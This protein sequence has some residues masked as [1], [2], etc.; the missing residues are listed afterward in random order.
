MSCK[1]TSKT[2]CGARSCEICYIRSFATH[3]RAECWSDR[4]EL[5][6]IQVCKSSNKKFWFDCKECGH[7]LELTANRV[8]SGGWCKYCNKG[9]LCDKEDC[10]PCF[11]SSF[12]SHPMAPLWS[13]NNACTPRM[14]SKGSEKRCWFVCNVCQHIY[15]SVLY[16]LKNENHCPYCANQKLCECDDCMICYTKSCASH[17]MKNAW[18]IKNKMT[19]RQTHLQSNKSVIFNCLTCYHEYETKVG[20]YYHREGSCPYCTNK[21]LCDNNTCTMCF[22]KSFAS[23][24]R[25]ACW[26]PKNKIKP[27]DIFKGSETKCIFNCDI[28]HSEF[29]SRLY[30]V[31][32]GYWCPFCKNKSEAKMLQ[33]LRELYPN[34]KSQ[35]RFDWCRFSKTNNVMPVDFGLLDKKILIELDGEQHF[36]QISNWD[37]PENVQAKDVEKIEHCIKNGYS[38]IHIYQVDV[39]KDSYDWKVVLQQ[40]IEQVVESDPT[41]VFISSNKECY[42]SHIQLLHNSIP[43]KQITSLQ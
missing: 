34:C 32:T 35:L 9:G 14:I 19:A 15:D 16:I 38:I 37:A 7:E 40:A 11:V 20:H 27:R 18:S 8:S 6:P 30:N 29:E 4:N 24:P 21:Y 12:A 36:S 28:C 13:S 42:Q 10:T 22:N 2:L 31:L 17:E 1:P 39:W 26:S 41:V 33:F 43:Y 3:P 23:H 25:I 5:L